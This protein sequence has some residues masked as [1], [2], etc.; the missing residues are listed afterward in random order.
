[1]YDNTFENLEVGE[2]L[3]VLAIPPHEHHPNAEKVLEAK[4]TP[5]EMVSLYENTT[6]Y[7]VKH[8]LYE[9]FKR[10]TDTFKDFEIE[11]PPAENTY[12]AEEDPSRVDN[13]RISLFG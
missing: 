10:N 6:D 2:L 9:Y 5:D 8:A 12:L 1:M 4:C 11:E 7:N 13:G 3:T